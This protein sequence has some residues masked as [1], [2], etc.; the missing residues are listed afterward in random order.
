MLLIALSW[1]R[2]V[3]ISPHPSGTIEYGINRRKVSSKTFGLSCCFS[4]FVVCG[5][6]SCPKLPAAADLRLYKLCVPTARG[7]ASSQNLSRAPASGIRVVEIEQR[8]SHAVRKGAWGCAFVFAFLFCFLRCLPHWSDSAVTP[9]KCSTAHGWG[10]IRT[11]HSDSPARMPGGWVC[12]DL[13][14]GWIS[15]S[16]PRNTRGVLEEGNFFL[17]QLP[18]TSGTP[19]SR[20]H[21][22]KRVCVCVCEDEG[23]A[24]RLV[25]TSAKPCK[26]KGT[27]RHGQ[28][29]LGWR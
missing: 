21:G 3:N 14:F 11:F 19:G 28:L 17:A 20:N 25:S 13:R 1:P 27:A 7:I 12:L 29:F 8:R 22:W 4:L 6:N 26:Q 23:R 10:A 24:A 5:R 15:E 2:L 9:S 18:G 16:S